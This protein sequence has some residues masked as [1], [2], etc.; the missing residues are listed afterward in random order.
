MLP[1]QLAAPAHIKAYLGP[2][3]AVRLWKGI[4]LGPLLVYGLKSWDPLWGLFSGVCDS[5]NFLR[6][7]VLLQL[8]TWASA[9]PESWIF[10]T[11]LATGCRLVCRLVDLAAPNPKRKPRALNPKPLIQAALHT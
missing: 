11:T 6:I 4:A 2:P 7:G 8:R 1:K 5:G 10:L 9:P 3:G